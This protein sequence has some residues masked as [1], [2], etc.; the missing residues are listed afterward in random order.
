MEGNR[1]FTLNYEVYTES[2]SELLSEFAHRRNQSRNQLPAVSSTAHTIKDTYGN[3]HYV[4]TR[5]TGEDALVSLLAAHGYR[6]SSTKQLARLNDSDAYEAEVTAIAQV[7]AY[8]D[9]SSKRISDMIP[10]ILE[11]V[12]VRGFVDDLR[13]CLMVNLKLVGDVGVANCSKYAQDEPSVGKKREYLKGQIAIL[14][15]GQAV[16][17]RFFN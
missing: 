9:L 2:K 10:M 6:I 8:F 15:K 7:L 5:G 1:P 11:T 3:S 13:R 4:K 12:F 17:S 16:L 14:S